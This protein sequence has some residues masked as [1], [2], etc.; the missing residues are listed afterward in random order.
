MKRNYYRGLRIVHN[1]FN[2]EPGDSYET[3]CQKIRAR[4]Q[5]LKDKG[6]GVL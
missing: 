6:Y 3:K 5:D 1:N 4:V 2:F